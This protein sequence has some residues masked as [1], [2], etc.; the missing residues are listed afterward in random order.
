M[1][2]ELRRGDDHHVVRLSDLGQAAVQFARGQGHDPE[3]EG[4]LRRGQVRIHGGKIGPLER[5]ARRVRVYQQH[6][7]P[8]LCENVC[9]PDR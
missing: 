3:W 1:V 9:Q 4:R 6:A 7:V 8:G 5:A 2:L